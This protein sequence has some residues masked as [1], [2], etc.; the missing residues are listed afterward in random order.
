MLKGSFKLSKLDGG[1][2]FK[3]VDMFNLALLAKQWWRITHVVDLLSSKILR[4]KYCSGGSFD[5]A[6]NGRC[7]SFIWSSLLVGKMVAEEIRCEGLGMVLL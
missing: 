1:L 6:T 2:G 5:L 3:D 7:D 4:A